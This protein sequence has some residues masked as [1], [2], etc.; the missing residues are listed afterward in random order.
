MSG[1]RTVRRAQRGSVSVEVAILAPVFIL[2]LGLA[3]VAGRAAVARSVVDSAAHD[4][5]RAA[6]I[7]RTR[8]QAVAD[9]KAGV[10]QVL[11]GQG[12]NCSSAASVRLTGRL[13]TGESVSLDYAFDPWRV[14]ELVFV[15]ATVRCVVSLDDLWMPGTP[16]T[17]TIERS[18]VSPMDRYRGRTLGLGLVGPVSP[19]GGGGPDGGGV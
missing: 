8:E 2:L 12:I 1:D 17:I 7:A 11:A 5:A 19:A 6:S 18:F 10:E 4:A 14:G 16:G 3:V 15:V 13:P 9:G